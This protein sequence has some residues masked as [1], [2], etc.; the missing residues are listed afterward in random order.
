MVLCR[1]LEIY[2]WDSVDHCRSLCVNMYITVVQ[3][4]FI[5]FRMFTLEKK[6][7]I[8]Q[9]II[10]DIYKIQGGYNITGYPPEQRD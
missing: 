10:Q 5:I 6:Q 8:Q 9:D 3:D 2:L 1:S 7:D 4:N